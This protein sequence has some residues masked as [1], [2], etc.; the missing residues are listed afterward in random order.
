VR[1]QNIGK[2]ASGD[3]QWVVSSKWLSYTF[4]NI[5]N[6]AYKYIEQYSTADGLGGKLTMYSRT[7]KPPDTIAQ[8]HTASLARK[9][10]SSES[11]AQFVDNRAETA[12]QLKLQAMANNS[13]TGRSTLA[14]PVVQRLK[15]AAGTAQEDAAVAF[16][17]NQEFIDKHVAND[18]TEA[19][20][21][22]ERR[23]A[24]GKPPGIVAGT[25]PNNLAKEADWRKAIDDS[26]DSVPPEGEWSCEYGKSAEFNERLTKVSVPGWE[27]QGT[28]GNVSVKT[29]TNKKYVGGLWSVDGGTDDGEGG[30]TEGTATV[31][32]DISHLTS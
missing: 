13:I 2:I 10:K 30:F 18:E 29:T 1:Y 23:I 32:M 25:A 21:V 12:T 8:L 20:Q 4:C 31:T 16:T 22:T 11:A 9:Q 5:E 28:A 3:I 7:D 17:L 27:A 6:N 24:T 14:G 19:E 26:T 15:G